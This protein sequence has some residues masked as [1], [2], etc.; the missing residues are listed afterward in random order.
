MVTSIALEERFARYGKVEQA[1]VVTDPK[2]G[3]RLYG[4]VTMSSV[5]EAEKAMKRLHGSSLGGQIITVAKARRSR[6]RVPTPGR[7]H[8]DRRNRHSP[9]EDRDTKRTS[10]HHDQRWRDRYAEDGFHPTIMRNRRGS[11]ERE[12]LQD[13]EQTTWDQRMELDRERGSRQNRYVIYRDREESSASYLAPTYYREL[14]VDS[15]CERGRP[16]SR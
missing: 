8:V 15:S 2:G 16:R 3:S 9:A 12:T 14:W 4:F 7:Y 6:P 11:R 10:N 13:R 1:A 5:A